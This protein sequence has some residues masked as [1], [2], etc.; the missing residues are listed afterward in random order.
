MAVPRA[1]LAVVFLAAG[2]P[3]VHGV[4]RTGETFCRLPEFTGKSVPDG[5]YLTDT[6]VSPRWI[7]PYPAP[8]EREPSSEQRLDFAGFPSV[9]A[10]DTVG[11]DGAPARKLLVTYTTNVDRV[12]T[13]TN[14]AAVSEDG[15]VT[16]GPSNRTPLREAP[17]ELHDGGLLALEYY[18]RR[19]GPGTA[20]LG[21][22]TS[23]SPDD[24]GWVRR[25]ATVTSPDEQ[26]DGG[27]AHGLPIQLAD[28][29]ILFTAYIRQGGTGSYQPEVFASEDGG[30][31]FARRGVITPPDP[32]YVYNE[33]ALAQTLDGTLLA[34][35]RRDGVPPST[36]HQS[37][38]SDGGRT[39]SPVQPLRIEGQDCLVRGV[40]PRLLL[41]PDGVL[42]LSAGRPHNWLAIAPDGI[43]EEWRRQTVTYRNSDGVRD[44]HGSSGYTAIAAVG[45]HR[46]VQVFDNCKLPGVNSDGLLNETA[47]PAHGKFE[48]G[49][50]Y[51]IK[52]RLFTV[53]TPGPGLLD[54]AALQR[55]GALKLD[56]D[57]RWTTPAHPRTGPA[58]AFDGSTDYWSGAVATGPGRYVLHLDRPYAIN[59]IGISLRPGHAASA[60]VYVSADGRSWGRPAV[61]IGDRT[62]YAMRY[63]TVDRT[64]A[65][66][67]IVTEPT[68]DCD[69]EIGDSCS[70]LNELELY[71]R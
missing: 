55:G 35:L 17:I 68:R 70:M 8:D 5:P 31:T 29:T 50:W 18:L 14:E 13:L 69:P 48:N 19:T 65:H 63:H 37:R 42:V 59:R 16:F 38:S 61:T 62:D 33:G 20:T 32:P 2:L 44:V 64:G 21:V 10:L 9:A 24:E 22:L 47:C 11:R 51:A 6:D 52:R 54:L 53:V 71:G 57:M 40:A 1:A 30:R 12:V 41:M 3:A 26:A 27:A 15:G 23:R 45:P 66:V 46:L 43:G 67:M 7:Y 34:V 39:W 49:G 28:G 58:G 56:T 36:L 25:E 4:A 60:R